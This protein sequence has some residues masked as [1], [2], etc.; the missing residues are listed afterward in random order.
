VIEV[1]RENNEM[2]CSVGRESKKN[3][4]ME[5]RGDGRDGIRNGEEENEEIE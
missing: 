3:W 5:K 4:R 1:G 2:K